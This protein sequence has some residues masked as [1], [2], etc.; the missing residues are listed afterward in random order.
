MSVRR[1]EMFHVEEIEYETQQT[2]NIQRQ[3]IY[4]IVVNMGPFTFVRFIF[5]VACLFACTCMV[6]AQET[7]T[8]EELDAMSDVDL[9]HIC[10]VRGFELVKDHLNEETGEVYTIQHVDYVAAAKQCLSIEIEM[11]VKE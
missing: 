7:Y 3:S 1:T 9:E 2:S 10:L 8:D 11:W 4:L 5:F 6:S